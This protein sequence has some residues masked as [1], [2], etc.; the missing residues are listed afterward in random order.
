MTQEEID[1]D[2]E[3]GVRQLDSDQARVYLAMNAA[4]W[5]RG[6]HATLDPYNQYDNAMLRK[7]ADYIERI[8]I[9][10]DSCAFFATPDDATN[11]KAVFPSRDDIVPTRS[12]EDIEKRKR[13]EDSDESF[14]PA[15]TRAVDQRCSMM[16]SDTLT[17][18]VAERLIVP[19]GIPARG[20]RRSVSRQREARASTSSQA[21]PTT[22]LQPATV[23][24]R[25]DPVATISPIPTSTQAC[26]GLSTKQEEAVA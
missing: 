26:P 18:N 8:K 14:L 11:R 24:T 22:H 4:A 1:A 19:G 10:V 2:F 5:V 3:I 12:E 16:T 25:P 23:T 13:E 6:A 9:I 20:M 21:A 15:K 17:E 7:M